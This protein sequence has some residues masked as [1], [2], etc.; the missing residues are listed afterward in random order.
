[1][2]GE[3]YP[4]DYPYSYIKFHAPKALLDY[5]LTIYI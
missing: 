4:I 5:M 3:E 1:M 2:E